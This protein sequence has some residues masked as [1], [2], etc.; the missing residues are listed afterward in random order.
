MKSVKMF[1]ASSKLTRASEGGEDEEDL[2][3]HDEARCGD[4]RRRGDA[5]SKEPEM[6]DGRRQE[7]N[8]GGKEE[9]GSCLSNLLGSPYNE[10]LRLYYVRWEEEEEEQ[11]SGEESSPS[12]PSSF[13]LPALP[14]FLLPLGLACW[15]G[16]GENQVLFPGL[17]TRPNSAM[18]RK[19]EGTRGKVYLLAAVHGRAIPLPQVV[20][21]PPSPHGIQNARIAHLHDRLTMRG[22]RTCGW[23]RKIFVLPDKRKNPRCLDVD[24]QFLRMVLIRRPN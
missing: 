2:G 13:L 15:E 5:I 22:I 24:L 17:C 7:D 18:G 16:R 8:S 12:S 6:K 20:L 19:K 21:P 10:S 4:D 23:G 9:E 14:P 1:F 11:E 3:H